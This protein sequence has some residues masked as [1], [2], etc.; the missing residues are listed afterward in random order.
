MGAVSNTSP[1]VLLDKAGHL[2][3]LEKLFKKV[4]I[5]PAVDIELAVC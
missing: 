1:L 3:I 4:V 2:W 5:L